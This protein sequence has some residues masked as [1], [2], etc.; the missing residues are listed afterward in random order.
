MSPDEMRGHMEK[1]LEYGRSVSG[2]PKVPR[3]QQ[4]KG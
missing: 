1:I 2:A 4:R 3:P